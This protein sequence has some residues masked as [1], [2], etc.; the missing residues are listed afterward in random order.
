MG[1]VFI[2]MTQKRNSRRAKNAAAETS[3]QGVGSSDSLNVAVPMRGDRNSPHYT[4]E[5]GTQTEDASTPCLDL[6]HATE[7]SEIAS[8]WVLMPSS[9]QPSR[10]APFQQLF[11][12]Q[13]VSA[14]HKRNAWETNSWYWQLPTILAA[15]PC[16]AVLQSIRALTMVYYAHITGD[17]AIRTEACRWYAKG[18]RS[19]RD[20]L[21]PSASKPKSIMSRS[22]D[23]LSSLMFGLFELLLPT[24][25][26]AWIQHVLA[27]AK[28]LTLRGVES[29]QAGP[30]HSLYRSMRVPVVSIPTT[31]LKPYSHL[32]FFASLILP[33]PAI[34]AT[35]PWVT[36]PFALHPKTNNDDL[37]DIFLQVPSCLSQYTTLLRNPDL[38][39]I[40]KALS[41]TLLN[42]A[43]SA[44]VTRLQD[45]WL[46]YIDRMN[47]EPYTTLPS[48]DTGG[49]DAY[50]PPKIE[51]RTPST[52]AFMG[53]YHAIYLI[54]YGVL[55]FACNPEEAAY[56]ERCISSHCDQI[57]AAAEYL[58]VNW[59]ET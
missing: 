58:F 29:C 32:Q 2:D 17:V 56:Y 31:I 11:V 24:T 34:F 10:A 16:S 42:T 52:A 18:L 43:A 1:N 35:E 4:S 41:K 55:V 22:E 28:L 15:A 25:P 5:R 14:Y 53:F 51:Y 45:W 6:T 3:S 46:E 39:P 26:G 20:L 54:L 37:I 30:A 59:K 47:G 40:N 49:T 8:A 48:L 21:Q 57:L 12:S 36:G 23:V 13:F 33:E 50:M 38:D 44:L 7:N 19:Q 27:S 9:N